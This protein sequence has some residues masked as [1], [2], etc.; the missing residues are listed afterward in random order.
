MKSAQPK[1]DSFNDLYGTRYLSAADI[2]KGGMA[3]TIESYEL[4]DLKD[5]QSGASRRRVVLTLEDVKKQLVINKTNAMALAEAYGMDYDA[6]V[7]RNIDLSVIKT[8][9][10]DGIKVTPQDDPDDDNEQANE[11]AREEMEQDEEE[12][13]PEAKPEEDD[14]DQP[15]RRTF[16]AKPSNHKKGARP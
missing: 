1:K 8:Q 15:P 6:W 12:S 4:E 11:H 16:R 2:P 14:N 10:G 7:G 9:M 5:K 13:D 3:A